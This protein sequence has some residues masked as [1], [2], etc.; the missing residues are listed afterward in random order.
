M[1]FLPR[2]RLA[3][4]HSLS[5]SQSRSASAP[6]RHHRRSQAARKCEYCTAQRM[7]DAGS[8]PQSRAAK[9]LGETYKAVES[10]ASEIVRGC[11]DL[12]ASTWLEAWHGDT[13]FEDD[14][15]TYWMVGWQKGLPPPTN[16]EALGK[17]ISRVLRD[18]IRRIIDLRLHEERAQNASRNEMAFET[19]RQRKATAER[20]RRQ[21]EMA[22]RDIA[23]AASRA[24]SRRC[25]EEYEDWCRRYDTAALF[26]DERAM[27]K[28]LRSGDLDDS[29]QEP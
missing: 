27:Q 10:E 17:R 2:E 16:A 18:D 12:L 19:W 21:R 15:I 11:S 28:Y 5:S 7:G 14:P 6:C 1:Q 9:R 4:R 8:I 26:R 23:A 20:Y 3:A 22:D 24:R 29:G 13:G 25:A